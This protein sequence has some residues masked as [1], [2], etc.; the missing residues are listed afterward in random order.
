M[1]LSHTYHLRGWAAAVVGG[2]IEG[3]SPEEQAA[4][5]KMVQVAFS[6]LASGCLLLVLL[7]SLLLCWGGRG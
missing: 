2:F 3:G 6:Y 4:L 5:K 7:R 1:R